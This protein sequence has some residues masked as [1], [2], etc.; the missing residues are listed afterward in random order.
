MKGG[1]V[2]LAVVNL[3]SKGSLSGDAGIRNFAPRLAELHG[4]DDLAAACCFGALTAGVV[5]PNKADGPEMNLGT[6]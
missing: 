4:I 1:S 3:G 5:R 6:L 2:S